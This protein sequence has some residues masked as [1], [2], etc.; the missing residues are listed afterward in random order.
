MWPN[1]QIISYTSHSVTYTS[2]KLVSRPHYVITVLSEVKPTRLEVIPANTPMDA[3]IHAWVAVNWVR[4]MRQTIYMWKLDNSTQQPNLLATQLMLLITGIMPQELIRRILLVLLLQSYCLPL[5]VW[6]LFTSVQRKE[7]EKT[8]RKSNSCACTRRGPIPGRYSTSTRTS[9]DQTSKMWPSLPKIG[10]V[11]ILLLFTLL[12]VVVLMFITMLIAIVIA[13]T[14]LMWMA[15]PI[16]R[17]HKCRHG[18]KYRCRR[19]IDMVRILILNPFVIL[20]E[21]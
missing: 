6:R 4:C 15:T 8:K 1:F 17:K 18:F 19:K 3:G 11:P 13:I 7:T 10:Y 12:V 2:S 21:H 5:M 16:S 14:M 20:S 9:T